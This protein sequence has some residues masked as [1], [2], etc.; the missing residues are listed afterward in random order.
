VYLLTVLAE[1]APPRERAMIYGSAAITHVV[2][3]ETIDDPAFEY[4][5]TVRTIAGSAIHVYRNTLAQPRVSLVGTVIP[6]RG[7]DGYRRV[8]AG[9]A[10]DLFASAALVDADDPAGVPS[11]VKRLIARPESAP[12]GRVGSAWIVT[13]RGHR[14]T[15]RADTDAPVVLVVSDAYL[16]QWTAKI[17]DAEAPLFRVNYAFRGVLLEPGDHVVELVYNP[18]RR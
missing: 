14:L 3:D 8:V 17:D 15:V 12:S 2:T 9:S 11:D 16:P 13:D 10:T 1:T 4:R 7:D 18:W 5:E 6:Y